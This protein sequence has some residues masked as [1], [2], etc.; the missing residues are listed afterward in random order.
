MSDLVILGVDIGSR[1]AIARLSI[2]VSG[3]ALLGV[4]D[5]PVL[6]DGPAGRLFSLNSPLAH[7][8]RKPSSRASALGQERALPVLSPL[9]ERAVSS[10]AFS[11]RSRSRRRSSRLQAGSAR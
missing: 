3:I 1:G 11:G 6:N 4:D 9:A 8:Q 10:R 2:G 7:T 5:M